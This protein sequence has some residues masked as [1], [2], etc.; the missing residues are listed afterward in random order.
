[1]VSD[2]GAVDV[3]TVLPSIAFVES[4][5]LA[6]QAVVWATIA[7]MSESTANVLIGFESPLTRQASSLADRLTGGAP[8]RMLIVGHCSNRVP[9]ALHVRLR[10]CR[11]T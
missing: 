11:F 6:R 1:M 7:A 4:L 8:G 9:F 5:L 10:L 2:G 3:D